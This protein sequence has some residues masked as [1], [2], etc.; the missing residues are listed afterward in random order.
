MQTNAINALLAAFSSGR[1]V[2][3][4]A[5]MSW[6]MDM[7]TAP[8]MRSGRRPQRSTRS[9]PGTVLQM[10]TKQVTTDTMKGFEMPAEVKYEVPGVWLSVILAGYSGCSRP[11][12][13]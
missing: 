12:N 1:A 4:L 7:P 6:E 10:L 3:T 13:P 2:P 9:K 5:T 11:G 8:N